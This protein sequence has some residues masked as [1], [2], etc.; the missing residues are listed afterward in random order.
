MEKGVDKK[1]RM[2]PNELLLLLLSFQSFF[3]LVSFQV[4]PP[5]CA[6]E[7]EMDGDGEIRECLMVIKLYV[8]EMKQHFLS[9]YFSLLKRGKETRTRM[10][11]FDGE[12]KETNY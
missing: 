4:I 11:G 7:D 12:E 2:N 9:G 8:D 6:D 3:S 1:M 5:S 10:S